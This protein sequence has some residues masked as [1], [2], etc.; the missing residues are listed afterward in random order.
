MLQ[1]EFTRD[2][3]GNVTLTNSRY[4]PVYQVYNPDSTVAQYQVWDARL[5]MELYEQGY[6][7]RVSREDYDAIAQ[8]ITE[9]AQAVNPETPEES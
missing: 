6:I 3:R 5:A 4:T 2:K 8:A 1:L 9:I 7:R